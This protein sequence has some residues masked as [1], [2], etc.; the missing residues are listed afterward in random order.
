MKK[1]ALANLTETE[2]A[3]LPLPPGTAEKL[4]PLD[5]PEGASWNDLLESATKFF[6]ENIDPQ[7][8]QIVNSAIFRDR[9]GC[10][11]LWPEERAWAINFGREYGIEVLSAFVEK[12]QEIT[13]GMR[14]VRR[15]CQELR[16]AS[17]IIDETQRD[18]NRQIGLADSTFQKYSPAK[19]PVSTLSAAELQRQTNRQVGVTDA[20]FSKYVH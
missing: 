9:D 15:K 3:N 5:L 11:K 2:F 4:R 6:A 12:R 14:L 20:T 1:I 18:V 8:E 19:K 7:I 13:E 17:A 10:S 16:Q